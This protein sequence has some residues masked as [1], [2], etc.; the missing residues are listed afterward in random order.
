MEGFIV[1][2][3]SEGDGKPGVASHSQVRGVGSGARP[4][5]FRLSRCHV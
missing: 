4:F 2:M 1:K 3:G 5:E